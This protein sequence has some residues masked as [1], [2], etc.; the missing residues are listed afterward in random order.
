MSFPWPA[1]HTLPQ[2]VTH[3][4]REAL[5]SGGNSRGFSVVNGLK[6]HKY[7]HYFIDKKICSQDTAL[8]WDKERERRKSK[9]GF[10]RNTKTALCSSPVA[11][12]EGKHS[13]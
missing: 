11:Q 12:E 1:T 4:G 8:P 5:C 10:W 9:P 6:G 2:L 7:H 13:L 3:H